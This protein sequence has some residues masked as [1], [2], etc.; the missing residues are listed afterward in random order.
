MRKI[1]IFLLASVVFVSSCHKNDHLVKLNNTSFVVELAEDVN[2]HAMGLMYRTELPADSGMLFIFDNEQPRAF[3]MKNTL[4]P[5]DILYFDRHK[6]LVSQQLNV[7][8][9][10]NTVSTCPSY[11][12][13]KAAKYVLE[14]NAGLSQKYGFKIGDTLQIYRK[15]F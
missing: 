11:P 5:L 2:S 15:Q 8:P 12:S 1:I 13:E 6:K 9:C 10:K 3:W 4:I 14:I 7:P